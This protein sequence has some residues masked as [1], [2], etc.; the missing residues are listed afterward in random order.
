MITPLH[1]ELE[2][3]RVA[4]GTPLPYAFSS[5]TFRPGRWVLGAC[6]ASVAAGAAL[7]PWN[8]APRDEGRI[9]AD[10]ILTLGPCGCGYDPEQ[11]YHARLMARAGQDSTLLVRR[12]P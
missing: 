11:E 8:A 6:L 1:W 7:L 10:G 9:R 2:I 12:E 3:A 5:G 4:D